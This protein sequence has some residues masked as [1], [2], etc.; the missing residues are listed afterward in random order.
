M[1]NS[2]FEDNAEYGYGMYL[3]VKQVRERLANLMQEALNM[4]IN[5]DLKD[6]FKQWLDSMDDG[7]GSKTTTVKILET[8][9]NENF[10]NNP[11]LNEIMEKKIIL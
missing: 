3:A 8:I 9:S 6:A 5:Q 4:E 7:E 1:G 10:Q 2:L 11:I